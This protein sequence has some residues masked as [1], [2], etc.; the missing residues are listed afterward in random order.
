MKCLLPEEFDKLVKEEE[1]ILKNPT[2]ITYKLK[3]NKTE[4]KNKLC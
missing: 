4:Y 1:K 3:G 2:E